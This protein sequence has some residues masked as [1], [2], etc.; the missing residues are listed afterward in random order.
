MELFEATTFDLPALSDLFNQYRMFYK[1]PSDIEACCKFL[2]ARLQQKDAVIYIVADENTMTGFVQLYPLFSSIRMQK[3]WLLNDLFVI[4]DARKKGIARMLI[5][6]CKL[7][8]KE[9][10]ASGIMLETG[11]NNM[12]GNK[13]YPS[14]GFQLMDSTHF[15]FWETDI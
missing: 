13:L 15:Y 7:L 5:D 8:A 3:C 6:R 12:E 9:S 11:K 14:E 10:N 1:Q 4:P 2:T